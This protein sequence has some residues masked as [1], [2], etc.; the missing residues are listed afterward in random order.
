MNTENVT[1]WTGIPNTD[2][3]A[4]P[5]ANSD[6]PTGRL[7]I[8]VENAEI[9][10]AVVSGYF[11]VVQKDNPRSNY[12]EDWRIEVECLWF[13]KKPKTSWMHLTVNNGFEYIRDYKG[14]VIS[15][16]GR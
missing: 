10:D 9:R 3:K 12:D 6:V 15:N 8:K 16:I 1:D 14:K 5:I 7:V 13:G 4:E 2:G 11:L